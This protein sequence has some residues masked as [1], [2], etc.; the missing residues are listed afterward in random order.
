MSSQWYTLNPLIHQNRRKTSE[1][2]NGVIDE[3]AFYDF[4][5]TAEEVAEHH[6]QIREGRNYF[7]G[8]MQSPP[9]VIRLAEGDRMKFHAGSGKPIQK[10]R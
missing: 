3:V 10:T 7:G 6:R 2:F 5:L 8:T 4:A 9:K 1:A